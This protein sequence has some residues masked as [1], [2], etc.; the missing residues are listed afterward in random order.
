MSS[1]WLRILALAI[2]ATPVT[3]PAARMSSQTVA[4]VAM[5]ASAMTS[6]WRR[7]TSFRDEILAGSTNDLAVCLADVPKRG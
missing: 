4:D 3:L 5:C 7:R 1:R 2:V 6:D